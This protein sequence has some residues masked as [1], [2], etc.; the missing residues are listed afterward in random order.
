MDCRP[1]SVGILQ[2]ERQTQ[3]Q[4]NTDVQTQDHIS[5]PG[6]RQE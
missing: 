5:H 4:Q 3:S 6:K 1:Q 2:K